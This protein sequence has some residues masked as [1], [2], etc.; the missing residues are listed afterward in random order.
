MPYINFKN[1]ILPFETIEVDLES[2]MLCEKRER[3]ILYVFTYT[4][5][6]K[7]QTHEQTKHKQIHKYDRGEEGGK[8]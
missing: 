4:W 2:V 8:G 5:N 3:Q 7:N 1:E 6:L